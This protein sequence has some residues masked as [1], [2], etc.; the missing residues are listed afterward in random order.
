LTVDEPYN[1][2]RF[3]KVRGARADLPTSLVIALLTPFTVDLVRP[4]ADGT[5][6]IYTA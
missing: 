5:A 4:I 6:R 1:G 3:G 2:A